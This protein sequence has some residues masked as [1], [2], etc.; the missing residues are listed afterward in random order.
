MHQE[1]LHHN[2]Y[3]KLVFILELRYIDDFVMAYYLMLIMSIRKEV[4]RL[5]IT[6][7]GVNKLKLRQNG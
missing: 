6:K 2:F 3:L 4:L 5:M 7:S 1:F